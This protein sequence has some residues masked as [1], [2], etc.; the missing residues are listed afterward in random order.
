MESE[1]LTTGGLILLLLWVAVLPFVC[2]KLFS[3]HE[4]LFPPKK[5]APPDDRES[6]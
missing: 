4:K 3:W 1:S 6:E 2:P 5:K